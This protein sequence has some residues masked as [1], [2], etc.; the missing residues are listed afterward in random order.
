VTSN[1]VTFFACGRILLR[2]SVVLFSSSVCQIL[3]QTSKVTQVP[4]TSIR[5]QNREIHLLVVDTASKSLDVVDVSM[6]R[7]LVAKYLHPVKKD[8]VAYLVYNTAQV[9]PQ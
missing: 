5:L 7:A 8:D 4:S 2:F 6:F 3:F 1:H 9:E